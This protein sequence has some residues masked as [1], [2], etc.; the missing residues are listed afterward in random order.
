[1]EGGGKPY[2]HPDKT[3]ATIVSMLEATDEVGRGIA[4]HAVSTAL[5]KLRPIKESAA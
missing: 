4:L 5:E 2:I 1:M 3:I